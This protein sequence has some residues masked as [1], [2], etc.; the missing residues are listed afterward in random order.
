[1]RV[2]LDFR[3]PM[4]SRAGIARAAAEL[5]RA[6]G[7]RSDVEL[8]LFADAWTRPLD[9]ER[10]EALAR[11][12]GGRLVRRRTPARLAHLL[13]RVGI[14]IDGR[15]GGADLFHYTDL[16][17]PPLRN[18]PYVMSLYDVVFELDRSLH[19]PE[20][21]RAVPARVRRALSGARRVLV[22]SEETGRRLIERGLC[23]ADRIRVTPLGGDHVLSLE[24]GGE[25]EDL[26]VPREPYLLCVATI[27]PRK[28]H[29][30]LLEAHALLPPDRRPPLVIAGRF[31]WLC[32][33]VRRRLA[34]ADRVL[35]LEDVPDSRL[36]ALYRG[37]MLFLYPSLYEGFGLP[38]LEAMALG[39]P[40][41]TSPRGALREVG[42]DAVAYADP[43]DPRD[44]RDAMLELIRDRARREELAGLGLRRA[45]EFTW[46]R[47][48]ASTVAAYREAVAMG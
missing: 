26:P 27:E 45:R 20:F 15:L 14:G 16:V 30:R 25:G 6:L 4:F 24:E 8:V 3:P 41:L 2:G 22:P 33:D 37:A 5:A 38:V 40:V 10:F 28:N 18:T 36:A 43:K 13:G 17:Y 42:G 39:V 9:P 32:D 31:G 19:G 48:A 34:G 7:R 1:M 46:D 23:G 21:H 47:T 11:A 44:L 29:L 35:H 12:T